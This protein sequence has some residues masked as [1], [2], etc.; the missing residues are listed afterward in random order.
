MSF[1][2]RLATQPSAGQATI[3]N[4]F[5]SGL[6]NAGVWNE[7]DALYMFAAYDSPTALT[8]MVATG[9]SVL[10]G[11]PT[12]SQWGGFTAAAEYRL[13]Q[14]SNNPKH[15]GRK[16]CTKQRKHVRVAKYRGHRRE[17]N[18]LRN[19]NRSPIFKS[20]VGGNISNHINSASLSTSLAIPFPTGLF[21]E[22]RTGSAVSQ[23][24]L[25]G[26]PIGAVSSA[27]SAVIASGT[28]VGLN[29]QGQAFAMTGQEAM[30]GFGGVFNRR[31]T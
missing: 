27:A 31:R 23:G 29:E 3:Y 18:L 15:R 9:S 22:D 24:Y 10:H 2:A 30:L 1:F 19:N 28:F 5:I 13:H 11:N 26:V 6:V 7:L 14:H 20:T 21:A 17:H 25:N 4:N 16:L 8:N 12:F